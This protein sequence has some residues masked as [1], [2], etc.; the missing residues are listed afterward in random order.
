VSLSDAELLQRYVATRAE[1]ALAELVRRHVDLV[2]SAALRQVGGDAHFAQDVVQLVFA[3]LVR[4]A[5]QL[6]GHVTLTGWL[7]TSTRF[8]AANIVRT[9]QRRKARETEAYL[10]SDTNSGSAPQVDL[11]PVLDDAMHEL[12]DRD[13]ETVLLRFFER[14]PLAEVGRRQ[15]V[16]ENAAAKIIE[17]ALDRLRDSFAKRGITSTGAALAIALADQAVTAAPAGLGSSVTA[18]LIAGTG[19]AAVAGSAIFMSK[20]TATVVVTCIIVMG[21]AGFVQFAHS[22][23]LRT[24]RDSLLEE[25]AK[26]TARSQAV[27]TEIATVK[28]DLQTRQRENAE[29]S[30]AIASSPPANAPTEPAPPSLQVVEALKNA[31]RVTPAATL[32]TVLW[33]MAA[34]DAQIV[35]A[36]TTYDSADLQILQTLFDM[37]SPRAKAFF[38]SPEAMLAAALADGTK[39]VNRLEI[40]DVVSSSDDRATVHYRRND[41]P[42]VRSE[43]F[44]LTTDGWKL[45]GKGK[46]LNDPEK[47]D[48]VKFLAE[49]AAAKAHP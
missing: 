49:A 5:D 46:F 31:G 40:V 9:E 15:G 47:Q 34:H 22:H 48:E 45:V 25:N 24:A 41:D 2:Y 16:S 13:R 23:T 35:A 18:S 30:R 8:A 29:L 38:K 21:G 44:R 12:S 20:A 26:Q 39:P 28:S 37:L 4:K 17:R 43:R 1:G 27:A 14:L 32:E 7:Y 19:S 3:D 10:M 36:C 42:T 11:R 33:A 6:R